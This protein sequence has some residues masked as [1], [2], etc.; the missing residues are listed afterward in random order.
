MTGFLLPERPIE[1]IDEWLAT[2]VGGLGVERAQSIGP[3]ATIELMQRSG[4]RGR[5]GA[6]FPTGRKWATVAGADPSAG[7]RYLVCNAAEGEPATFKDR[8]LMRANPY[9]MVE[10]MII[11]AF[12]VGA[13]EAFV[14]LKASFEREIAAVT[15]AIEE[16]QRAG[17]CQDCQFTIVSG[18]EEYLYGEEKAMMEVI[19]GK[20]PLPRLLAPYEHGLF[21]GGPL[22]LIHISEPTRPY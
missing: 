4:L 20:P 13:A 2:D 1:S 19:E 10:G 21:T 18:P 12:A 3:R 9:Q 15:R 6:G 7:T 22:S 16:F 17:I 14:C 11:A 5:G 8:T